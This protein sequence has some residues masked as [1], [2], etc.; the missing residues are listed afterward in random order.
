MTVPLSPRLLSSFSTSFPPRSS[1]G[2]L[3]FIYITFSNHVVQYLH[4]NKRLLSNVL[5]AA[6]RVSFFDDI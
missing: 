3:Y 6:S 5:W 2:R 1:C 4:F